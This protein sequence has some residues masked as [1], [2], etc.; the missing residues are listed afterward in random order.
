MKYTNKLCLFLFEECH[1]NCDGCFNKDRDIKNLPL[2]NDFKDYDL[3]MLTDGEP[4]LHPGVTELLSS[5]L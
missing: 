4:M 2:C 1:R 3:I 5:S